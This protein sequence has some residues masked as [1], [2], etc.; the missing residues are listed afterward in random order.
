MH[1][2]KEVSHKQIPNKYH[3]THTH[4]HPQTLMHI[5]HEKELWLDITIKYLSQ[6]NSYKQVNKILEGLLSL[7]KVT[8]IFSTVMPSSVWSYL[9]F[10]MTATNST[11]WLCGNLPD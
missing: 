1:Q 9:C 2:Q 5:Q 3:H 11:T 7:D 4:A 6:E 8:V 10:L